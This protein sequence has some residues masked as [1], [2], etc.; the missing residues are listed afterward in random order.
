MSVDPPAAAPEMPRPFPISRIGAGAR[1]VVE[2]SPEERRTLA[3]RMGL[4]AIHDLTCRFD[5]RPLGSNT[6][7]AVGLLRATIRQ[8]CVVSLEP[9]DADVIEPF[10]VHFVPA[11]H[12]TPD[13]DL[14]SADEVP[15]EGG[16]LD[17][18]EAAAEQ[19][20]L[21]LDPFPRM[22]GAEMAEAGASQDG[23][24]FSALSKL[25]PPN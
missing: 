18:G 24:A 8:T 23:G 20:A 7:E 4:L 11:G 1:L 9:F 12:E 6:I 5:L 3:L 13:L 16:V 22:P 21:A 10:S 15:Y 14:E 25:L 19:L 17:L 2:A